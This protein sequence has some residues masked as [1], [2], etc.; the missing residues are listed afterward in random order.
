MARAGWRGVFT[1]LVVI[2]AALGL[3][4]ARG[5]IEEMVTAGGP[6]TG[7]RALAGGPL[8]P[9][10]EQIDV[11]DEGPGV[12]RVRVVVIDGLGRAEANGP[13]MAALCARSLDLVIDVGFPTKSLAVQSVLWTGLTAQQSGVAMRN[14]LPTPIWYAL[15]ARI[16]GSIAVVESWPSIAAAMGFAHV[17]AGEDGFAANAKAAVASDAELVMVHV[18]DVDETAH[19]A[20][21]GAE[22]RAAVARADALLGE[23]VARAPDAAWIV[24][25]DHGHVRRG[26]HG[27]I[28]Q[29]VRIVRG[30]I[31]PRPRDAPPRGE[32]HLVDV[33]RHLHDLL[34][35]RMHVRAVGRPL[36]SAMRTVDRDATLPR[37]PLAS[38]LAAL[39]VFGA[40]LAAAWRW[41]RPR[42]AAFGIVLLLDGYI[43]VAGFP[44]LSSREP[45]VAFA[46][47]GALALG[48]L[49]L[50]GRAHPARVM[51]LTVPAVT[52]AAAAAILAGL[53]STIAGGPPPRLPY[54]TAAWQ[55]LAGLATLPCLVGVGLAAWILSGPRTTGRPDPGRDRP[56]GR[57]N[58]SEARTPATP[59]E[60]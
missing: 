2:G 49:G 27:D 8:G 1:G 21:R 35:A 30:C 40:G 47:G 4:G 28:E 14:E 59:G 54:V 6:G 19:R 31:T 57:T 3:A 16:E 9:G 36:V 45:E 7:Q 44:S 60:R 33:S 39:A 43:A 23:L 22:Y 52:A 38:W 11:W 15:P 25:S 48:L 56:E 58:L 55:V 29:E 34:D 42:A 50:G 53:P 10:K 5:A 24:L 17:I 32:V 46:L 51:A 13:Q 20:G 37:V 12:G 26:G 41:G 18:L